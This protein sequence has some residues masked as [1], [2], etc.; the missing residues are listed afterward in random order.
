MDK[1]AEQSRIDGTQPTMTTVPQSF[2]IALVLNS[3]VVTGDVEAAI[4]YA[5]KY[6]PVQTYLC[7]RNLW[8][9]NTFHL[10]DW[11]SFGRYLKSIP[12]AKIIKVA[13]YVHAWQNTG[14][15]KAKFTRSKHIN[16]PL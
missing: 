2:K 5:M 1:V 14:H 4:K 7:Q 15:Q 8:T 3:A 12:M 11:T 10:I 6:K 16:N 9:L 13:K